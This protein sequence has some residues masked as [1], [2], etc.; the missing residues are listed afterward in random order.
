[1]LFLFS[2]C[3]P[4]LN[5][6]F[7][8]L[9]VT[10]LIFVVCT[11]NKLSLLL[12]LHTLSV[13]L[14][15]NT[16]HSPLFL[17]LHIQL[18][19]NVTTLFLLVFLHCC[20]PLPPLLPLCLHNPLTCRLPLLPSLL[21][22]LVIHLLRYFL[23]HNLHIPLLYLI[24]ILVHCA[25]FVANIANSQTLHSVNLF[26]LLVHHRLHLLVFFLPFHLPTI[27]PP[28]LPLPTNSLLL[29]LLRLLFPL[30]PRLSPWL[31]LP[32]RPTPLLSLLLP[33]TLH[34]LLIIHIYLLHLHLIIHHLLLLLPLLLLS[35]LL[36]PT[37]CF[38]L[39]PIYHLLINPNNRSLRLHHHDILQPDPT[40]ITTDEIQRETHTSGILRTEFTNFPRIPDH[41]LNERLVTSLLE[42]LAQQL[43]IDS[44]HTSNCREAQ[45]IRNLRTSFH[46][47]RLALW[48]RT[49]TDKSIHL[50][51]PRTE[52][53][54]RL[55]DT[56]VH[57]C[58]HQQPEQL[59]LATA[60]Q[61]LTQNLT[62]Q[63][64]SPPLLPT[65]YRYPNSHSFIPPHS[66]SRPPFHQ[67]PNMSTSLPRFSP[68]PPPSYS[69]FRPSFRPSPSTNRVPFRPSTI[70][71]FPSS[72]PSSTYSNPSRP[73]SSTPPFRP[74]TFSPRPT[75]YSSSH[76]SHTPP[77]SFQPSH[78]Q[79][80]RPSSSFPGNHNSRSFPRPYSNVHDTSLSDS[81]M[82]FS[83]SSPPSHVESIAISNPP[84]SYSPSSPD[85]DPL[86]WYSSP[87]PPSPYC[88]DSYY[89]DFLIP[90]DP[91]SY[92]HPVPSSLP[93]SPDYYSFDES[94]SDDLYSSD[95]YLHTPSPFH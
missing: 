52:Y 10:L 29:F 21:L 87:D 75:H 53:W 26:P 20:K 93:H 24:P 35:L 71:S 45:C 67:P 37:L 39:L 55:Y 63:Q 40:H 70:S 9:L 34:H 92:D 61:R 30:H 86:S 7:L 69:P 54:T 19:L 85:N 60:L 81:A 89:H 15:A 41:Q 31:T 95:V 56:N 79:P 50:S 33:L 32:H 82:D 8:S 23:L 49:Y 80:S 91:Y 66:Y 44:A 94:T 28:L 5:F 90:T 42:R 36:L 77:S 18:L 48:L 88:Y 14:L 58:H 62:R 6:L 76:H 46:W 2:L 64:R 47:R 3:L 57:Y 73:S 84:S 27:H 78:F 51:Y 1:M 59:D 4:L 11:L 13:N 83:S 74:S 25:V 17:L 16:P 72:P 22:L 68:S 43:S 38:L 65:P 12:I